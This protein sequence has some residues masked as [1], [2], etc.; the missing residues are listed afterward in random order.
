MSF[1]ESGHHLAAFDATTL[2]NWLRESLHHADKTIPPLR[3]SVFTCQHYFVATLNGRET[4]PNNYGT[5]NDGPLH[6]RTPLNRGCE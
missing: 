2:R 1:S 4:Y 3:L 5:H 6:P